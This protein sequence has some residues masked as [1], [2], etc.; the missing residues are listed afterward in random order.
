MNPALLP[1]AILDVVDHLGPDDRTYFRQ[2]REARFGVT[3][4]ELTK[5][6]ESR[7]PT[8]TQLLEPLRQT[9]ASQ[10]YLGGDS[11]L[12]AD[13]IVFGTLMW[14]RSISR[15]RLIDPADPINAWSERM[16]DDNGGIARDAPRYW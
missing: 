11:P 15:M 6:R 7:L 14:P 10:P 13:Y 5:D 16:L 3:L 12:Y 8:F 4:E 1:F 9:L 2:T